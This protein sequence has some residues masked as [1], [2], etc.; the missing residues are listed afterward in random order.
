MKPMSCSK[1]VDG[2]SE[3]FLWSQNIKMFAIIACFRF[4]L[5]LKPKA[6]FA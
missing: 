2:D 1:I 6:L 4:L 3:L 5:D